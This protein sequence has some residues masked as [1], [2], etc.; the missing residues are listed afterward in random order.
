MIARHGVCNGNIP[1]E[2]K[3]AQTVNVSLVIRRR[4]NAVDGRLE[5]VASEGLERIANIDCDGLVLWLYPLPL[6]LRIQDLQSSNRLAE[7]KCDT[8]EISVTR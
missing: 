5:E 7:E 6:L 3:Y 8:S 1:S 4:V 2:E